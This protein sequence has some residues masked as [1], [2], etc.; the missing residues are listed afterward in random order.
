[1]L[2]KLLLTAIVFAT[3]LGAGRTVRGVDPSRPATGNPQVPRPADPYTNPY[4]PGI[5][6][7]GSL[8]PG[9]TYPAGT[10]LPIGLQVDPRGR[11]NDP[12][13]TIPGSNA[14]TNPAGGDFSAAV[15]GTSRV[16]PSYVAPGTTPTTQQPS[17]W[18][19]GVYSKD[20]DTGVRIIQVVR[21][22]AA[23]RAGLE[24]N[25]IIVC[26]AGYQV[27]YVN[28]IPYDCAHEFERNADANGWVT[29]L[30]QNNRD[31]K[32]MSLPLQLDSRYSRI[33]G[34]ITYRDSYQ[35][36]RDAVATIE[37]R[38]ILRPGAPAVTIAR[39]Q[40]NNI[41]TVPIQYVLEY[42][43]SLID[44][45]RSYVLSATI[46]QGNRTLYDTR[47]QVPVINNG[48]GVNNVALL[49]ES[50]SISQ[51]GTPYVNRDEQIEQIVD[52]FRD[53]LHRD[54]R[55]LELAA[56]QAHIDRGGSL[57][58]AQVQILSMP[59]YYNR[60]DAS[61]VTYI[62]NLH[63]QILGKQP[64]QEEMNYWIGR[65]NANNRLRPEVAREFLA[66]VGTP[67]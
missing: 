52:W 55:A 34:N 13:T 64:T 29:L 67:R 44:Q 57:R 20:T 12:I 31:A 23:D 50:T 45:R 9:A 15:N 33:D 35:L 51:P 32:L 1:M 43:P 36:P 58:D 28:G 41:T 60:A 47:R 8:L 24:A 38:E 10:S 62:R 59:E 17:K 65:M 11:L 21:G 22:S 26:V 63:E 18:R 56:W 27:G 53:Y 3:A 46:M 40:I 54:P 2:R 66:A 4:L 37:L 25:D 19:L 48:G 5:T 30:V 61:D 14:I 7:P 39:K 49:V 6:T 42:D 16:A